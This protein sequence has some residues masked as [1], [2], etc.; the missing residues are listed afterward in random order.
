VNGADLAVW[1]AQFGAS[2]GAVAAS[3]T[4]IAAAVMLAD[5]GDVPPASGL[6]S[7]GLLLSNRPA[8]DLVDAVHA[9]PGSFGLGS[10]VGLRRPQPRSE[11]AAV[12]QDR[13]D[14]A[15]LHVVADRNMEMNLGDRESPVELG[16]D[17][18]ALFASLAELADEELF[19]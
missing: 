19:D 17:A 10:R 8:T 2:L 15:E 4:A 7:P 9:R 18:D 1:Q 14:V 3:E 5:E 6:A 11:F 16:D 13:C 12:A